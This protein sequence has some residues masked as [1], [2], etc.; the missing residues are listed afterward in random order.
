MKLLPFFILAIIFV[1]GCSGGEP[2]AVARVDGTPPD[3]S[4]GTESTGSDIASTDSTIDS[5]IIDS[6]ST[7]DTADSGQDSN[8]TVSV[9][10]NGLL[11]EGE[12]CDDGNAADSDGCAGTCLTQDTEYDCSTPGI[13]CIRV[14]VCGNGVLEGSEACDEGDAYRTEGCAI[15][16]D[17]VTSGWTCPRPGRSCMLVPVCGDGIRARGEQC[18]D[19]NTSDGDGC[20]SAC[21]Q[22]EGF[23]CVPGNLCVPMVCGDGNRTPDE[24]CDD[25]N[26]ANYDGCST[27]CEVEEGFRCSSVG[28]SP[29]CGDGLVMTGE[30]CDDGNRDS[31]DG[32]NVQC[33]VEPFFT[34]D[35]SSTTSVCTTTIDCGNGIMEPGE[36]CDP[37]IIG[38]ESC[39][40]TGALACKGYQNDLV[41]DPVCGNGVVEYREECDGD[42]GAGCS[43]L[44]VVEEG[45]AC[46]RADYCYLIPECGDGIVQSGES[47]DVGTASSLAC[48]GCEV[49]PDWYCS[50]SPSVCVPSVCQDGQ[51]APDEQCDDG[52]NQTGDGC[53]PAC[54]VE[55]GWK[56]PPGIACITNCGNGILTAPEQCDDGNGTDGDGCTN[57]M[58][59]PGYDC[60]VSGNN[61]QPTVCGNGT[62]ESGEGCDDGNVAAGDGCGVTCQLEPKITVGSTPIV[63][64]TCGDGLVTSGEQCDDGNTDS[65]D[66]CSDLCIVEPGWDCNDVVD[67]PDT[68]SIKVTYRDFKQR[69][70]AGGHPH[71]KNPSYNIPQYAT[72]L[73]IVGTTCTA[74][75]TDTCGILDGQGKPSL[76]PGS[77]ST[78]TGNSPAELDWNYHAEAFALWYRD[79]NSSVL[80]ADSQENGGSNLVELIANPMPMPALGMDTLQLARVSSTTAYAFES[81][82]NLFYPLGTD[83]TTNPVTMRGHGCTYNGSDTGCGTWNGEERNFHFT[84]EL[85]YFFQYQGGETLTFFGDDDVWV[86]VNGKLAVDIGGIHPTRWG[87]VVLGDDGAEGLASDSNCTVN[88]GTSAPAAC[89]LETNEL[90]DNDDVRFGLVKGNVYEIVIFQAERSPTESNYRL[91]LDGFIAPRS[92]CSTTCGDGVVA[93]TEACDA[94][95]ANQD[96]VYG[97]CS[98]SCDFTYCGDGVKNGTE[99]CDNGLN[100]DSP[101]AATQQAAQANCASEC[102][103]PGYCGDS[104]LQSAYEVCDDGVNDNSYGGCAADCQSLGG[105]C[106]DGTIDTG[107]ETC[108]PGP[109]GTFVVYAADGTGC[110]FDCQIAP[111][112]GDGIRNGVEQC[113]GTAGCTAQCQYSPF[114][115]DG[116]LATDGSEQCDYGDFAFDPANGAVYGGCST[117]CT[118]GPFCGDGAIYASMEECDNG[119]TN[120]D[121]AYNGCTSACTLGPRCGDGVLQDVQGEE[122]DNGYNEDTYAYVAD[123]C[124][125]DCIAPPRCGDGIVQTNFEW[126]D[127]GILNNDTAY[128]GC[129]T[130]CQWGP[131]CGDGILQSEYETCDLGPDNGAYAA[132]GK[133]CG[134]DCQP[135]PFCGD[136]VRNGTES[137]DC[138]TDGNVG[139][140]DGCKSDCTLDSY[141][142]DNIIDAEFGEECDDGPIGSFACSVECKSRI[143]VE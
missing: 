75:N 36:V 65:G 52:N 139:G 67:Y 59:D 124:G 18:D 89:T 6:A 104:I 110:G 47:C 61:C 120:S 141:C 137:C 29:E 31:G 80:D 83:R 76:A 93:G 45:Y 140:Y 109:D 106:G 22:Q 116:L 41:A 94:G 111:Y 118:S 66:G 1:W 43:D 123:A 7:S 38:H 72:E 88:A 32:C 78:I 50:G 92:F 85:R 64:V 127:N 77:H 3:T 44:C 97:Q 119:A 84:S 136:G 19:G 33:L 70:R 42:N 115:G 27:L 135:A 95:A 13:P 132:D 57:C 35:S 26:S 8:T 130:A 143:I 90:A 15:N 2:G 96:G 56:C 131:Y 73:G 62:L 58:V 28:C 5:A 49:Q 10:G 25:G 121:S 34:C 20:S 17:A 14:A 125:A 82:G 55:S 99:A 128:D 24:A 105:Y 91:T 112:C 16:C 86:F 11:E 114:C 126:C 81:D 108:D 74:D 101:W 102:K 71:M 40:D 21:A 113:D 79:N 69:S 30:E 9:C 133:G 134:Y 142:G 98:T 46:P 48:D 12:L 129:T 68:L 23:F 51:R 39:Y 107:H 4:G 60:G 103:I 54:E 100:V 63:Q 117:E 87:R 37:G 53:S 122:C 138:G